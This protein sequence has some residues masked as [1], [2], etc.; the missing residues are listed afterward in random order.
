ML[1]AKTDAFDP[2]GDGFSFYWQSNY[3]SHLRHLRPREEKA[4]SA[5]A[6][7]EL[8]GVLSNIFHAIHPSQW[9]TATQGRWVALVLTEVDFDWKQSFTGRFRE[10]LLTDVRVS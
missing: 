4:A 2:D 9:K 7:R 5:R 8:H 10:Y 3:I 6:S 1:P